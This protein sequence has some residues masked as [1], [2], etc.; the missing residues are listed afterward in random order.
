MDETQERWEQLYAQATVEHDPT[1]M[2]A[3]IEEIFQLLE[4]KNNSRIAQTAD[5]DYRLFVPGPASVQ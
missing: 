4:E 1:K 5:G 3:L 2:I